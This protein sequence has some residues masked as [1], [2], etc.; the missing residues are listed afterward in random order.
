MNDPVR[1]RIDS[2]TVGND[3]NAALFR[4][5]FPFYE[6]DNHIPVSPSRGAVGSSRIPN[7]RAA[8]DRA[9]DGHSLLLTSG[10]F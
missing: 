5:N 1:A 8:D 4:E 2:R 10:K 7:L 3:H 6:L 9:S